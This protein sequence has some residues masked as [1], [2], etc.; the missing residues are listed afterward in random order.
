[1]AGR[2]EAGSFRNEED[3]EDSWEQQGVHQDDQQEGEEAGEG[4]YSDLVPHNG[5][6]AYTNGEVVAVDPEDA[7]QRLLAEAYDQL[8]QTLLNMDDPIRLQLP[9]KATEQDRMDA[10]A[11]YLSPLIQSQSDVISDRPVV[12][13]TDKILSA[14]LPPR[15]FSVYDEVNDTTLDFVQCVRKQQASRRELEELRRMFEF[16]L[17]EC[18]ARMIGIC[19]VRTAMFDMLGDE[20]LRQVTIDQP[21]RGL[22]LRRIRDESK[23]TLEAYQS[24]HS[25]STQYGARK[26]AEG[27]R[28]CPEMLE[29]IAQLTKE[30]TALHLEVKRLE[31]RHASLSRCVEEQISS[32]SKRHNEEKAFLEN[33]KKRL[34]QHLENVKQMQEQERRALMGEA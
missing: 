11:P 20:L 26:L 22:L 14:V 30:T 8:P 24:L 6:P 19:P 33:S 27:A 4:G 1:M 2:D 16:K 7:I 32:D 21:E 31:A 34:Q 12:T 23:M 25:A 17:G 15:T 28:G 10:L 29:R 9:L 13:S 18:K 5:G 3:G